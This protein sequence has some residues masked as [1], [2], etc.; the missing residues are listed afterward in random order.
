MNCEEQPKGISEVSKREWMFRPKQDIDLFR[1]PAIQYRCKIKYI[2]WLTHRIATEE[3]EGEKNVRH[4]H[5]TFVSSIR[6]LF[7]CCCCNFVFVLHSHM[8]FA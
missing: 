1:C 3:V 4:A 7:C 5:L 6:L 8:D 2:N